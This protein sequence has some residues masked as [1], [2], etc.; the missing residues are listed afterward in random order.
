[1][2]ETAISSGHLLRTFWLHTLIHTPYEPASNGNHR[3]AAVGKLVVSTFQTRLTV[4][5]WR[6]RVRKRYKPTSADPIELAFRTPRD[7][8][9]DPAVDV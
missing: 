4:E 1:M 7:G 8:I 9:C 3:G 6:T 5:A 2:E